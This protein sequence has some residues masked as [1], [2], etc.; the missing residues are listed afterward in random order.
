MLKF[1]ILDAFDKYNK[2]ESYVLFFL[3]FYLSD[4][5]FY[6][7]DFHYQLELSRL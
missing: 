2:E 5:V 1:S 6:M 7:D 3:G 4:G